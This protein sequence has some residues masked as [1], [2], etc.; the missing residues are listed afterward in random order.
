MVALRDEYERIFRGLVRDGIA[1]GEFRPVD[2]KAAVFAMLG[3]CNWFTQ[4]YNP[5]GA[6]G[7]EAFA[8]TFSG[9]F[10]DGLRRHGAARSG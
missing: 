10:L 8:E 5:A 7:H 1:S 3:A 4:W 2:E 9:L 6:A